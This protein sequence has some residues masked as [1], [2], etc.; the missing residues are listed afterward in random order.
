MLADRG[1]LEL[2]NNAAEGL[3]EETSGDAAEPTRSRVISYSELR[4][5]LGRAHPGDQRR[6]DGHAKALSDLGVIKPLV[7]LVCPHCEQ[8][9]WISPDSLEMVLHCERCLQEF[10]FP[11]Q[12]PPGRDDWGYRPAGPFSASGYAHGA[13]SVALSLRFLMSQSLGRSGSSW[14]VGL[15]SSA[16]DAAF[17]VD[18]GIWL[19][20]DM[21]DEETPALLLGEAKTF[22]QFLPPDFARA[23]MLLDR[24]PEAIVVFS[25]LRE[26]LAEAEKNGLERL[27]RR[28]GQQGWYPNRRRVIVLT[29]NELLGEAAF[30]GVHYRWQ[31][32]GGR[33]QEIAERFPH[34]DMELDR[35]SEATTALY[36]DDPWAAVE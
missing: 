3:L 1:L 29:G 7:R 12:S 6:A 36:V 8:R 35:L 16:P 11:A 24:F 25:T 14:A 21:F 15:E 34:A 2:L 9:N 26:E 32:K 4:E 28:G 19:Q 22:G 23:E 13:Y 33:F 5:V 20:T 17:E 10:R 30:F 27:L 18:F 31:E